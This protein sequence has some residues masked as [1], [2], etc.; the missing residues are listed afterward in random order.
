MN[1]PKQS[2][3]APKNPNTDPYRNP[4]PQTLNPNPKPYPKPQTLD[5]TTPQ[6]LNPVILPNPEPYNPASSSVELSQPENWKWGCVW[7]VDA[8]GIRES[9]GLRVGGLGV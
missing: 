6:T 3:K 9:L 1:D 4:K 5:P 7:V 2:S 8:L